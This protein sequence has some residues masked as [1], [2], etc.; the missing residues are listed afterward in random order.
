MN[1]PKTLVNSARNLQEIPEE[2]MWKIPLNFH[3]DSRFT[4]N[5]NFPVD[6]PPPCTR[7]PRDTTQ[8]P[9][10]F[11]RWVIC[12]IILQAVIKPLIFKTLNDS[13]GAIITLVIKCSN[14][15]VECRTNCS[16]YGK[17]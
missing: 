11:A 9:R 7:H 16:C 14:P 8:N 15:T 17:Q 12:Y 6:F 4:Y 3:V 13:P 2:L 1:P 10:D 5:P